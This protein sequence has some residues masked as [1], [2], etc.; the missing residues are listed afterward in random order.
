MIA[1]QNQAIWMLGVDRDLFVTVRRKLMDSCLRDF[2]QLLKIRSVA[3]V[4]QTQ[5]DSA[6][7]ICSVILQDLFFGVQHLRQL[8]VSE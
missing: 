7:I 5:G 6:A 1:D 3:N 4:L 2:R 8:V